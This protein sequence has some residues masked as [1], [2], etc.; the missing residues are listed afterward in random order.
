MTSPHPTQ[1]RDKGKHAVICHN[2]IRQFVIDLDKVRVDFGILDSKKSIGRA[3]KYKIII[4]HML[5]FPCLFC[6]RENVF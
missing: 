1:L 6:E 4:G 5:S 2:Y 3:L